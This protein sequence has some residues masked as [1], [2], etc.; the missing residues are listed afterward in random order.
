[1]YNSKQKHFM[2]FLAYLTYITQKKT[3]HW[4]EVV[5][6]N[7]KYTQKITDCLEIWDKMIPVILK[8]WRNGELYTP[9]TYSRFF[10]VSYSGSCPESMIEE[11]FGSKFFTIFHREILTHYGKTS[12]LLESTSH[13]PSQ[14]TYKMYVHENDRSIGF[15]QD[16][17]PFAIFIAD[18][19]IPEDKR[20]EYWRNS[21]HNDFYD[22]FVENI[23]LEFENANN[24][25]TNRLVELSKTYVNS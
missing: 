5:L 4:M 8:N 7:E 22:Y 3:F 11:I 14:Y 1:M 24:F 19:T 9:E 12:L 10:G 25:F 6:G 2:I 18:S 23:G 15:N 17:S 20:S 13:L 16:G 21:F